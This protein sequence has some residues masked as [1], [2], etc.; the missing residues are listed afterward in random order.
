MVSFNLYIFFVEKNIGKN[1]GK[2]KKKLK[3]CHVTK[4]LVGK[5]AVIQKIHELLK[6]KSL[7]NN[8]IICIINVRKVNG[9]WRIYC[10]ETASCSVR[11]LKIYIS[12]WRVR[13]T[14]WNVRCLLILR[15]HII[16]S[17]ITLLK[18]SWRLNISI[19]FEYK[20][21]RSKVDHFGW[22]KVVK[23]LSILLRN[24]ARFSENGMYEFVMADIF[25]YLSYLF[26]NCK[27]LF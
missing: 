25:L 18:C 12:Q 14:S 16:Y 8:I 10:K 4:L 5:Q 11:L 9:V 21:I 17:V 15:Y 3:I 13:L 6:I 7:C 20:R 2:K 26:T 19:V 23:R 27:H 22:R 1:I 24:K